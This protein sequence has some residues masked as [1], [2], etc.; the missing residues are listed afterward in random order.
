MQKQ[1][2]GTNDSIPRHDLWLEARK[3]KAGQYV[4]E[5]IARLAAKLVQKL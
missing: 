5:D 4:N 3:N 1:I 2:Q